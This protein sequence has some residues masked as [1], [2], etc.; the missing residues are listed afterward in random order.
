VQT[1]VWMA[2]DRARAFRSFLPEAHVVRSARE[3]LDA[4]RDPRTISFL[5][6][7]TLAS[8]DA[9][10]GELSTAADPP[11]ERRK[12]L[13][14]VSLGPVVVLCDEPYPVAWLAS[15]PWLAH[16]V[17]A[18][19]L[20]EPVGAAHLRNLMALLD[21]TRE[22][23]LLDLMH[24]APEGRRVK[25]AHSSLRGQ[26]LERM[27]EFYLS[28]GTDRAV[29]AR[30]H[31]VTEGLLAHAFFDA[32][33]AAGVQTPPH[34]DIALPDELACDL[35]YGCSDD[36]AFVRVRDP[37]GSLTRELLVEALTNQKR[38]LGIARMFPSAYI[39]AVSV[40]QN[41]QT[42]VLV[43]IPRRDAAP[44]P[45]AV[46]MFFKVGSRRGVWKAIDEDTGKP[47]STTSVTMTLT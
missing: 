33:T 30:I 19:L 25:L 38:A 11:P 28:K 42:E 8:L 21:G 15:H 44:S 1:V 47:G 27:A 4:P 31:D 40:I 29:A 24:P 13:A 34:K 3:F 41:H 43:G 9:L 5:D 35:V 12:L 46:H 2:E 37:F 14:A 45:A 22:V 10:A 20:D 32:P 6:G 17:S 16:L 7:A 26:R 39:V 18:R 36:I 23:K